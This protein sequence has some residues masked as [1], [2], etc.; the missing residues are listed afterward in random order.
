MEMWLGANEKVIDSATDNAGAM[1]HATVQVKMV[2]S[3]K[4]LYQELGFNSC[5]IDLYTLVE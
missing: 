2:Y 3:F 1:G 5:R 4:V